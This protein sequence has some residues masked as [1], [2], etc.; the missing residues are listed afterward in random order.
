MANP[1]LASASTITGKISGAV[2]T[3]SS[4]DLLTNSAASGKLFR[5]NALYVAN[6]DGTNSAT[7]TVTWYNAD[8]TTSYNLAK[9]MT[10]PA[11]ATLDL[12]SKSIYLEEGDKIAGL[13]SANASLHLIMSYEELS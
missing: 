8:N 4:A 3:T 12:I 13:A 1:N 11:A 7:A 6:V 5:L 2:L 10:V 9:V